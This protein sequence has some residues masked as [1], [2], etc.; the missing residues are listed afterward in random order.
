HPQRFDAVAGLLAAQEWQFAAHADDAPVY[1]RTEVVLGNTL[2]DVP[3]FYAAADVAFVGGSLVPGI[4]GHNVLE[5]ALLARPVLVGP[6][7]GE[8]QEVMDILV[9]AGGASV[10]ADADALAQQL[11]DWLGA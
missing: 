11:H 4:G 3:R 2:G 10:A 8:W 6:H 1:E 5:A 9:A 7:I